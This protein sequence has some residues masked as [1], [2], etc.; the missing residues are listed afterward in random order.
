MKT[1][2]AAE[3][4]KK[5][6]RVPCTFLLQEPRGPCPSPGAGRAGSEQPCVTGVKRLL[7][8]REMPPLS[9]PGEQGLPVSRSLQALDVP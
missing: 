8:T 9:L 2:G 1:K 3:K 7:L 6:P 5:R 4:K